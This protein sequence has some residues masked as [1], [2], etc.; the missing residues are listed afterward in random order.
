MR[1]AGFTRIDY[2][3]SRWTCVLDTEQVGKLYEGFS[4]VQRLDA[5]SRA[6]I[7]TELMVIA[8]TDF[9]G[10]VER[11]ITSCLFILSGPYAENAEAEEP[12]GQ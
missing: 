8:D 6:R 1:A 9:G 7:L 4:S 11:N 3:E 12:E 5:E 10:R 2:F